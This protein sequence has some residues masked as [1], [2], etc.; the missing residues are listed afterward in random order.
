[1]NVLFMHACTEG[2][3]MNGSYVNGLITHTFFPCPS[4]FSFSFFSV[5]FPQLIP[6]INRKFESTGDI[7][8]TL[9]LV[10]Q[11]T[12]VRRTRDLAQVQESIV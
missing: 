1:M 11:S 6:L 10:Q 12:G 2:I 7:Q 5:E 3:Y 4:L 9:A 8:E